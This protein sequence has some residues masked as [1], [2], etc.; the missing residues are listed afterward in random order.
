MSSFV[1]SAGVTPGLVFGEMAQFNLAGIQEVNMVHI[2]LFHHFMT[3][4]MSGYEDHHPEMGDLV[5]TASVRHALREPYLMYQALALAARHLCFV[6]PDNAAFYQSQAI[7][8]QTRA[9]AIFNSLDVGYLQRTTANLVSVFLFSCLLGFQSL[10][11]VLSHRDHDFPTALARFLSYLRLHRGVNRIL[12]GHGHE[13]NESEVAPIFELSRDY[14]TV[15]G[16][17]HECDDI[18]RRIL[19]VPD[20]SNEAL[21]ATLKAIDLLQYVIDA[22]P[23]AATRAHVLL[24]WTVMIA[25]EFVE[26][27]EAGRPEALAVL[28]YYFLAL[29]HCRDVWMFCGSGH[30]LLTSLSTYLG[31]KWGDWIAT[32]CRLL[33]ESLEREDAESLVEIE[34]N[35]FLSEQSGGQ[36]S[37]SYWKQ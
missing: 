20:L 9:I 25:P 8:L 6:R 31:P 27:L 18:R 16:S 4:N 5:K 26:L 13:L 12:E 2:E 36:A 19:L 3:N 32:P 28:G 34:T 10:C 22:E 1:T 29:H 37:T 15:G 17:G 7:H 21:E 23:Q 35:L 14:Y 33:R 30:F 11:D 24:P